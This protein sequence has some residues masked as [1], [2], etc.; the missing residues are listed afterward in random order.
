MATKKK[1]V[2]LQVSNRQAFNRP[3]KLLVSAKD[4]VQSWGISD[5]AGKAPLRG[6]CGEEAFLEA[7]GK[8]GRTWQVTYV[9]S[10]G[11]GVQR[12]LLQ[13]V[14]GCWGLAQVW[15]LS[16]TK[17]PLFCEVIAQRT[18]RNRELGLAHLDG[19]NYWTFLI[20]YSERLL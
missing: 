12:E 2:V 10:Q 14:W 5:S 18:F 16:E 1:E 11:C 4:G 8:R 20:R 17:M 3:C 9:P 7:G 15:L 13:V 6:P 19:K